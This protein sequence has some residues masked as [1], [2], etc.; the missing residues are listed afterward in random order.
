MNVWMK[1]ALQTG[2]FT[3]GLLALGSG[4]AWA[5]DSAVDVTVPVTVTDNALAVLG[6][7]G[8][9]PAEIQ[10]PALDG[11]VAA[12]LGAI[13]VS[14]PITIAGNAADA[15]GID[16]AQPTAPPATGSPTGSDGSLVDADAPVTVTGNAVA[17]LGTATATGTAPS[18]SIGQSGSAGS[19]ASVADLDVPVLVCGNGVGVLGDATGTCTTPAGTNPTSTDP[20]TAP[21]TGTGTGTSTGTGGEPTVGVDAP[22]TA[23]G[24]GIAV[25]GDAQG[26]CTAPAADSTPG[27]PVGPQWPALG[28]DRSFP[29][30]VG[31]ASAGLPLPRDGSSTST[32]TASADGDTLAYTGGPVGS[33]L[34]GGLLALTLGIAF[35]VVSRR[36]VR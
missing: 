16:I 15:A 20:G 1:R 31:S 32:S 22:V 12:D 26:T 11:T 35:T 27:A 5:D 4:I 10:L 30:V 19:G 29:G 25:L 28:Q 8:D 6:T 23:C 34:L 36:R 9:L 13:T 3:G 17:V 33:L 18:G 2:L 24:L 21:G 7:T 14:V